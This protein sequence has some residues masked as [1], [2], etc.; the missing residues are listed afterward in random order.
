MPSVTTQQ[1]PTITYQELC[2]LL[3]D[4]APYVP[5]FHAP[6]GGRCLTLYLPVWTEPYRIAQLEGRARVVFTQMALSVV[7][8][9]D[10]PSAALFDGW[11]APDTDEA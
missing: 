10:C 5:V 4:S 2:H 1:L 8:V 3:D 7:L 9:E 11:Q 6:L